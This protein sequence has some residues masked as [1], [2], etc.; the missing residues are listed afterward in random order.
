MSNNQK[1]TLVFGSPE[2]N[3]ILKDNQRLE[4]EI[5]ELPMKRWRVCVEVTQ[6]EYHYID[7]TTAEK[8]MEICEREYDGDPYDAWE[9]S[10]PIQKETK[11]GQQT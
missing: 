5:E 11:H 7:A 6:D 10:V 9:Q 3:A 8:A 1:S 4:T 2:A